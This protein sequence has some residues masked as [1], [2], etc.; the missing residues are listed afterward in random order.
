MKTMEDLLTTRQVLEYLKVDRITVYRMLNDGRLKGIKIGQHWRLSRR[1]VER[2]LN[3]ASALPEE[4]QKSDPKSNFPTHC[5][6]TIQ[7]LFS[8]VGQVNA[9]IVDPQGE[10]L[11]TV[12]GACNFCELIQRSPEGLKACQATWEMAASANH[13]DKQPYTCHAGLQYVTAPIMAD[14]DLVGTFLAGRFYW[15]TPNP[16]EETTRL[17][18]LAATYDLPVEEL[19]QAA[20]RIQVLDPEQHAR[21]AAWPQSA[22]RAVQSILRERTGFMT[23][24]QKISDLTQIL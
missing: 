19:H 22:A 13:P 16:Q 4:A 3:G 10:P 23:R 24:L 7:D 15:Q 21:I 8:E 11:T 12:T 17:Q 2:L 6:Q 1:E 5:V 20:N 9:L 18:R 14:G